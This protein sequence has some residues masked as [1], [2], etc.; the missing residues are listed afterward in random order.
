[1]VEITIQKLSEVE[2]ADLANFTFN[3]LQGSV[4]HSENRT[5]ETVMT[6]LQESAKNENILV[7]IARR[8]ESKEIVGCL[9]FYVG[10]S[11]MTFSDKWHPLVELAEDREMI[12]RLLIREYKKY[13]EESGFSRLEGYLSPITELH[14][15]I[16]AEYKNWFLLEGFYRA[17][18]EVAMEV[19]LD[20]LQLSEPEPKLPDGFNFESIEDRKNEDIK[21]SVFET[22]TTGKDR[23]FLDLTQTQQLI[24]YNY[25]FNRSRPFHR[26]SLIVIKDGDVVGSSVARSD[27]ES[28]EL[29]PFGI[30]PKHQGKGIGNALMYRIMKML[31][32]D[33]LKSATLEADIS[34]TPA[35]NLYKKYGF[36][37]K[38]RQEY[39]A[40]RIE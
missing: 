13:A 35:T 36:E 2:Q 1:M 14:S 34:N 33:G 17:T 29:G 37:V 3:V 7:L 31:Q 23:L 18:E 20:N 28:V 8:K 15:E 32:E 4:F 38:Y 12:A 26:S 25:W 27:E 39:Y 11:E 5:L 10:F 40:W 6:S 9:R 19:N 21:D 22:F 16:Q 30:H 24:V